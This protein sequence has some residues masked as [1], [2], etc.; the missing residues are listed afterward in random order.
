MRPTRAGRQRDPASKLRQH[1]VLLRRS[2]RPVGY[3]VSP[4]AGQ[5]PYD[6]P[7]STRP[8]RRPPLVRECGLCGDRSCGIPL[9]A[10]VPGVLWLT[11]GTSG[12]S[13][14]APST[15]NGEWPHYTADL[16]GTKYSPLDQIN[17]EQLQ[18]ARGRVAVQ[19]RQPRHA[20]R[21]QAR[22]H[23]AD[24]RRR[25]LH[26]RRH[27]PLGRRARR[28]HA[29]SCCGCTAIPKARAAPTLRVSCPAAASPTGPTAA[30]TTAC[31]T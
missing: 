17:A 11:T 13:G 20:S 12:Q 7:A 22:R 31:S 6:R 25:A 1:A 14:P 28:A 18:Q 29:A 2:T 4:S 15:K 30:A 8:P 3:I 21:V 19:D 10:I 26:D 23:A 16:R 24:G 27:A 5:S 9:A